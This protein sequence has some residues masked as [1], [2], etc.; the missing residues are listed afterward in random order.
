MDLDPFCVFL[1]SLLLKF[2]VRLRE[3]VLRARDV[4]VRVRSRVVSAMIT[5]SFYRT[6]AT[7]NLLKFISGKEGQRV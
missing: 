3:N 4:W 5:Y 6:D 7:E 1:G 2:R